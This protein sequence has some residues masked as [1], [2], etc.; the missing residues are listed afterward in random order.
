MGENARRPDDR[1]FLFENDQSSGL[2]IRILLFNFRNFN[3]FI[4]VS[5]DWSMVWLQLYAKVFFA[6][7]IHSCTIYR[8]FDILNQNRYNLQAFEMVNATSC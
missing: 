6:I 7:A 3:D 4:S 1:P 2:S 8:I 5:S